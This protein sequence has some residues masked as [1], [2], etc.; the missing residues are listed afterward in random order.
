MAAHP[1]S[2]SETLLRS[3]RVAHERL[4]T[5]AE[6]LSPEQFAWSGGSS[7]HSVAWQLWH[8]ARWDDVFASYFHKA[9]AKEPR[10]QVW[11]RESLADRW[12][13]ASGSL[14]RRDTG[15]EMPDETAEEMRLPDQKQVVG[16]ARLAFAYAEEAIELI[17][18]DQLLAIP[19]VDPDGDTKLD[20]VLIYLEHLSRHLGTIE[21]IRGL[22]GPVGSSAR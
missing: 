14:G 8:T 12:S 19:K 22:Q 9:L 21:S 3:Y 11:E 1:R 18:D 2:I 13:L 17:S 7:L 4:L 15:T 6:G 20:N 16:Y 5:A 10:T